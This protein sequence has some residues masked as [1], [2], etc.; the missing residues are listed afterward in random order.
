MSGQ[1][2]WTS[3]TCDL[4]IEGMNCVELATPSGWAN[5]TSMRHKCATNSF[6]Y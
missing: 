1:Q 2:I 5:N 4:F 6:L 3:Y